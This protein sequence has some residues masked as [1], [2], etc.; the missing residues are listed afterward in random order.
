MRVNRLALPL[1]FVDKDEKTSLYRPHSREQ[2][3]SLSAFQEKRHGIYER[4]YQSFP[5]LVHY[6]IYLR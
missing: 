2:G 1:M 5:G 4:Y 3:V 6:R